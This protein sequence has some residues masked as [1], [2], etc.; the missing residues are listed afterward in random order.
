MKQTCL[1]KRCSI[2]SEDENAEYAC[3]N[4]ELSHDSHEHDCTHLRCMKTSYQKKK[5]QINSVTKINLSW[6]AIM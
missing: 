2:L 1:L 3:T 6:A 5:T 4:I